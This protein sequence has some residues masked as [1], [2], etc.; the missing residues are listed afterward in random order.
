VTNDVRLWIYPGGNPNSDAEAW[1]PYFAD[2]SQWIRRPGN[3][4]GA[5]ISYSWGK[6]DESTQT[7]AGQM[8]LTLDNRDGR[9][10]TDNLFGPWYGLI[11][12]NTPIRMGV[13]AASDTFT[14]TVASGLGSINSLQT[15]AADSGFSVDGSKAQCIV[16]NTNTFRLSFLHNATARDSDITVSVYP[17]AAASGGSFGG[18]LVVRTASDA[19]NLLYITIE[20]NTA[21]DVT[22]KIRQIIIGVTVE[23]ASLNPIPSSS[24][25][26]GQE[27]KLRVQ[28]DGANVRAMCWAASGSQPTSWMVTADVQQI[29]TGFD[30]GLI[31]V[32][33]AGNTN[34]GATSLVAF[35]NLTVIGLE[36]TGFVVSWPLEW[37]ITGNNSWARITAGGILRRLRQGT[38]PVQSPLRRQL[39][40]TADSVGYWPMEEGP[41]AS[42]FSSVVP[43][44]S[45]ATFIGLTPGQDTSLAGGGPAP[46]FDSATGA[47]TA[48]VGVNQGGTGPGVM[49][50][51]KLPSQPAVKTR[52]VRVKMRTGNVAFYD[53][54]IDATTTILEAFDL[55][56]TLITS[57]VN[58]LAVDFTQWVAWEL[59]V[60]NTSH[61]GNNHVQGIY[62]QVGE[63][64]YW[65]QFF[66][67]SGTALQ[68][69]WYTVLSGPQGI[70]FAHLWM[71]RNTAPFSTTTFNLV[72]SGYDGEAAIDRFRRVCDEAGIQRTI[73]DNATTISVTMGIQKE[74]GTLAVLQ[75][76]ADTEYGVIVERGAGLEFIVRAARW[77]QTS[78]IT[79]SVAAGQINA[80]PKPVRDDQRLRNEWQVSRV[81]GGSATYRDSASVTRNGTWSDSAT[82][83]PNDDSILIQQAAFRT[84]IGINSRLRWPNVVLNFARSP[85]LQAFWQSRTYGTRF[86]ITTG[87]TQ[88]KGN[89]PDLIIEGYQSTLDPDVWTTEMNCTDAGAWD[90]GSA[91]NSPGQAYATTLGS[92]INAAATT[93]VLSSTDVYEQWQPGVST[94][95]VVID[96]EEIALGT[97]GAVTGT[98][99]WTQTVT[100][101]TR[102]VN[103]KVVSHLAGATVKVV[104]ALKLSL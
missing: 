9:F 56:G 47:I 93:L 84:S 68:N 99:P 98:G 19:N 73:T 32:R 2:I 94:A 57:A 100:G 71:G 72:S 36:W 54:S 20:Y 29:A 83:N 101:C 82:I 96:Y 27:W 69:L 15:W 37:D 61:V 89:E 75:S 88:V 77:N 79:L 41:A 31:A 70:S 10:S 44:A 7:D 3:D 35:D 62:H 16:V 14:R 46:T 28:C 76:C 65:V 26:A 25:S 64:L 43:T 1:E 33:F 59:V 17:Q 50:F 8:T 21:G 42:F 60:D 49:V 23:L 78:A 86:G 104:D 87:L 97:I 92:G 67:V 11:D 40:S 4:G 38:N 53:F 85:E 48:T 22:L 63:V 13:V 103:G 58:A 55:S 12:T 91:D 6:Q 18:G 52:I 74:S 95:H 24:Y 34:S 102:S 51:F 81:D 80:V 45:N 30:M 90:V 66:D 5:P 39:G